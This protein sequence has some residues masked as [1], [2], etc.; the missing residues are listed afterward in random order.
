MV[1][2]LNCMYDSKNT[3]F[4]VVIE[5]IIIFQNFCDRTEVIYYTKMIYEF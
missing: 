1:L 3:S 5:T 4:L 2:F